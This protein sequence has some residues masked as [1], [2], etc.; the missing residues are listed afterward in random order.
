MAQG[1]QHLTAL[2]QKGTNTT[3]RP[4]APSS[5]PQKILPRPET[6]ENEKRK[7]SNTFQDLDHSPI[8][9]SKLFHSNTIVDCIDS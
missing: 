8:I 6:F 4:I 2:Q 1:Q 7:W 9:S 3:Y 5:T